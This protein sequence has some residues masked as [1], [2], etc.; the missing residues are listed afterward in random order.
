MGDRAGEGA[1]LNNL[2][3][4]AYDQGHL[5]EA[6][7]YY[8]QALAIVREVGDRAGE[9]TTLHNIASVEEALGQLDDAER[10]YR[11]SLAVYTELGLQKDM[12]IEVE[13]LA[14]VARTRVWRAFR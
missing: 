14:R 2:G 10:H 8:E 6:A 1:T 4:L 5:E 7:R 3:L 9:A 12:Q 11:E 13:A